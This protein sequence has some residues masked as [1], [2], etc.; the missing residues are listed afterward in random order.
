[1]KNQPPITA[2]D[3]AAEVQRRRVGQHLSALEGNPL[4]RKEAAM[5]EMF[6][7]ERWSD[8]RRRAYIAA[9]FR[10]LAAE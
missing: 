10:A 4:T 9:Q 2:P 1:M 3:N 5:F 6:E 8:D 7:R